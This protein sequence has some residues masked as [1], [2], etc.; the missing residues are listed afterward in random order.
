MAV[1]LTREL[2]LCRLEVNKMRDVPI[3]VCTLQE[4]FHVAGFSVSGHVLESPEV[5][6]MQTSVKHIEGFKAVQFKL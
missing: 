4:P 5:S 1:C 2:S 3:T 6:F